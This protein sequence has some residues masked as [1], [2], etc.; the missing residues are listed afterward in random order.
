MSPKKYK[1]KWVRGHKKALADAA[2]IS[3]QYLC[4]IMAERKA[5]RAELATR[6]EAAGEELGY[7]IS[8]F[9]W[10]FPSLR[11]NNPLFR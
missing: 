5:C 4:D 3:Q 10:A 7:R 11:I 6:L 1:L 2:G 9:Q 8:R